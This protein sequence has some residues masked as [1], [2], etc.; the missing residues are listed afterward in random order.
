MPL[1]RAGAGKPPFVFP[2]AGHDQEW[3]VKQGNGRG[4]GECGG[5]GTEGHS[6][7]TL[8]VDVAFGGDDMQN[9]LESQAIA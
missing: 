5:P 6:Q 4:A 2:L 7:Y 1:I 9:R 3:R 8:R